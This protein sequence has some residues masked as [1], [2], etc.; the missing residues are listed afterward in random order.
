M[1][2]QFKAASLLFV[3]GL[4]IL[5]LGISLTIR[6]GLGASPFDALLVGLS[7][8][9]G[10]TVGSWEVLIAI[11]LCLCNALLSRQRPEILGL[12]TAFVTGVGIDAWLFIMNRL[13]DPELLLS[14]LVCFGIGLVVIGLGTAVYLHARFAPS[15]LDRLTLLMRTL[16]GLNL[17]YTRT[18]LYVIF[19]IAA[20]L[21]RGP[22]GLGTLLTVGLGGLI[23]N[24]FMP[25][26][27]KMLDRQTAAQAEK[28]FT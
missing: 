26:I 15:P 6:A 27:Q 21:F 24:H 23:L 28:P 13:F 3:S 4:L 11:L 16:T 8:S 18:I 7:Q 9:V 2:P 10:L 19:L 20:F 12:A 5:T 17:F 25:L 22:I 14:K 1:K